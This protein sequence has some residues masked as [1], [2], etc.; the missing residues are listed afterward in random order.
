MPGNRDVAYGEDIAYGIYKVRRMA[1]GS[2][3][4]LD[5]RLVVAT[6]L[7]AQVAEAAGI[8]EWTLEETFE[9]AKLAGTTCRHPLSGRGTSER[10]RVGKEGGR[11]CGSRWSPCH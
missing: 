9:G 4:L 6:E 5:E 8:L 2:R 7:A 11:T 3:A 1:E 10:R